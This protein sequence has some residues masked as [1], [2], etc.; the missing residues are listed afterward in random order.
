M[1]SSEEVWNEEGDVSVSIW[2][3]LQW[4][5]GDEAKT[6]LWSAILR[7][8]LLFRKDWFALLVLLP[9]LI[10][11]NSMLDLCHGDFFPF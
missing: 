11:K 10:K 6:Q 5:E 3:S 9:L 1:S 4:W 2:E 8:A 7:A